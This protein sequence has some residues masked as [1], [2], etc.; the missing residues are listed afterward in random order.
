MRPEFAKK[1]EHYVLQGLSRSQ[2][3]RKARSDFVSRR[4]IRRKSRTPGRLKA[5]KERD[6]DCCYY[7]KEKQIKYTIDHELP[8][9]K[10]GTMDLSNLRIACKKCNCA[11]GNLTKQEFDQNK[12][13]QQ[14]VNTLKVRISRKKTIKIEVIRK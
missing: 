14:Y 12:I 8:I 11:K 6:G 9:S 7:C 13:K 2:A 4:I 10:G 1:I 5:I 3:R